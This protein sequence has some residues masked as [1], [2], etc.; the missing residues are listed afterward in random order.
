MLSVR[1]RIASS[2]HA[3]KQGRCGVCETKTEV[4]VADVGR[5]GGVLSETKSE[6]PVADLAEVITHQGLTSRPIFPTIFFATVTR[7]SRHHDREML[8]VTG[9]QT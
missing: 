9:V 7:V 1:C 5:K 6:V 2:A 4:P 3:L 8:E